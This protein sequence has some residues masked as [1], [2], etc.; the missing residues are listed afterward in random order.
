MSLVSEAFTELFYGSGS[1]LGLILLMSLCL[2]PTYKW[3]EIGVLFLPITIFMGIEYLGEG[4]EWHG[5]IMILTAIFIV[6]L[7]AERV[8]KGKE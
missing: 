5:L 2:I 1:W 3:R 7:L 4:L 8:K 6:Y